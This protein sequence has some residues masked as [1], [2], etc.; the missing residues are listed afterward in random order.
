LGKINFI[1]AIHFHQPVGQLKWIN[2]RIYERSYKLLLEMFEKYADLKFTVHISGPLLLFF[3]E[4]YPEWIN[5]IAKLGDLGTI[6]FLAGSMGEAILPILPSEDRYYQVKEY[7]RYFEKLFGYKPKGMWLPERV[8]EPSLPEVLSKNMIEYVFIDDSTLQRG[9]HSSD[10]AYYSWL[11]EE[12]GQTLKLFFIDTGLRYVLPWSSSEEVFNYILSKSSEEGDRVIVWGSDAE[13]F[14][15]WKDP[16]WAWNWLNDFLLKLRERNDILLVHPRDYLKEHGVK[17]LIYLPS[18]SYDKMLE[19]SHGFFRNFLIKYAES[20]NM[21]KKMLWVRKK[22]K[23]A[24]EVADIAWREYHLGQ[25]NDAYW[26]GL[27]GGIY[28]IHLRQA[29]YEK[30]IK[31]EKL[32]EETIDYYRDK[33]LVFNYIDFD[34]DGKREVLVETPRYNIYIKPDDGGTIFEYDYK[35]K[36]KEHNIQNTMTRY[37]EPYLENTGFIPDWYRR[38]SSRIHLWSPDTGLNDWINNTPFKDQSDL[39]LRKYSVII[40]RDHKIVLRTLGGHYVY[41]LK[42][43]KILVEK[44]IEFKNNGIITNYKL[45]NYGER[46]VDTL[47]GIEYHVSPKIDLIN[48]DSHIIYKVESEEK[49]VEEQWKGIGRKIIVKSKVF[50]DIVFESSDRENEIWVSPLNSLARTEKG[51]MK[52]FQGIAIMFVKKTVLKPKDEYSVRINWFIGENLN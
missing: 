42:P 32:A 49:N 36:G 16:D 34:Y 9:G 10:K 38:V 30:F 35:E 13:K 52:V 29:I 33:N 14:G 4:Y 6:E 45:V 37:M 15:E 47:I 43:A 5:R 41:G 51:L 8:Y 1:F 22:L 26:H 25:C 18:G 40:T 11:T 12:S 28:L 50:P 27:F 24:P 17:G 7:M 44:T 20:N 46:L 39:A 2:D 48:K 31:V 3:N 23:Q 21:H 19:W